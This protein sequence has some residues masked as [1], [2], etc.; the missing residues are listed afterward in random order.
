[1]DITI[2]SDSINSQKK[3]NRRKEDTQKDYQ[4]HF[5]KNE[6]NESMNAMKTVGASETFARIASKTFDVR[7][8]IKKPQAKQLK[9]EKQNIS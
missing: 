3:E 7:K 8:T 6:A 4:M 1:M 2:N 9:R 5:D